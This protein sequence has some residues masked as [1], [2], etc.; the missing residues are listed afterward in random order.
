MERSSLPLRCQACRLGIASLPYSCPFHEVRRAA[1]SVIVHQDERPQCVWYLRRGQVVFGSIDESGTDHSSAVRGPDTLL[2]VEALLG[3][4]VPYRIS[5]LTDVV[6]CAI[7]PDALR[8]WVG[9]LESPMGTVLELALRES[10]KRAVERQALEGTAVRR[11]ARY[12]LDRQRKNGN[13]AMST[14]YHVLARVLGMRPET[15]SR[16]MSQ[17][18]KTGA[19]APG[20]GARI[21]DGQRLE[22]LAGE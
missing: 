18:R 5:A 3:E 11:L 6:L 16:A 9:S 19:I 14:P 20:R 4:P 12:L 8:E 7:E 13:G 2:A 22:Q 10:G 21:I 17:L 15:L 1:G